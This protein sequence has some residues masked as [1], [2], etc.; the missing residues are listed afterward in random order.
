MATASDL[1]GSVTVEST[2]YT[3]YTV[4]Y[5]DSYEP[6]PTNVSVTWNENVT[7]V[8]LENNFTGSFQNVSVPIEDNTSNY[9]NTL[10]AGT[11]KVKFYGKN[12]TG[13]YYTTYYKTFN[14]DRY[15]TR[16]DLY[17]NGNKNKNVKSFANEYNITA[18]LNVEKEFELYFDNNKVGT[19]VG[20]IEYITDV[21]I[22]EHDVKA[23]SYGNENYTQSVRQKKIKKTDVAL[24]SMLPIILIILGYNIYYVSR[25]YG[26]IYGILDVFV[27]ISIVAVIMAII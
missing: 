18:D 1:Q 9:S 6:I 3:D 27:V 14:I 12:S 26:I 15:E 22:G 21:S 11:Y 20:L 17:I 16:I 13:Y 23:I 8:Y 25:R 7:D 19:N 4:E 2:Y 5:P 10:S 24:T